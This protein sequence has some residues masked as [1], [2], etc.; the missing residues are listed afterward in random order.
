MFETTNP[1]ISIPINPRAAA[2]LSIDTSGALPIPFTPA[3]KIAT[4]LDCAIEL[5]A[6]HFPMLTE[7]IWNQMLSCEDGFLDNDHLAPQILVAPGFWANR[8]AQNSD[9]G[10]IPI[11]DLEAVDEL[12]AMEQFAVHLVVDR[13]LSQPTGQDCGL[14][15]ILADFSGRAPEC[16]FK[17]DPSPSELWTVREVRAAEEGRAEVLCDYAGELMAVLGVAIVSDTKFHFDSLELESDRK[18]AFPPSKGG[19][20]GFLFGLAAH[21]IREFLAARELDQPDWA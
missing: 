4:V 14:R 19:L 21:E 7:S 15:E 1:D 18:L 8:L 10:D 5:A 2:A 13:F 17:D 11:A 6:G 9:V 16:V 20:Y 3:A 12:S